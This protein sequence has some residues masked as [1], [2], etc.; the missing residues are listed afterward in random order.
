MFKLRRTLAVGLAVVVG[1][2][3][4]AVVVPAS[5]AIPPSGSRLIWPNLD[6]GFC[7]GVQAGNV[8][9]G[10]P[11]IVWDC[12]G[13]ADQTWTVESVNGDGSAPFLLRNGVNRNKCLSVAGQRTDN[14]APLVIWDCKPFGWRDQRWILVDGYLAP[15]CTNIYNENSVSAVIGVQ[16]GST[17]RGARVILWRWLGHANQEWCGQPAPAN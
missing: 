12:N 2:V 9:N 16:G 14:G 15:S 4:T 17:Q 8:T 3:A 10:T 6:T 7:L 5:A 11:I 13:N 1:S